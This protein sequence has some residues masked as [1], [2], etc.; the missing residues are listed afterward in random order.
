MGEGGGGFNMGP[1]TRGE[2]GG[3]ERVKLVLTRPSCQTATEAVGVCFNTA[4]ICMF[5]SLAVP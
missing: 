5:M 3:V 1:A 4:V 2:E